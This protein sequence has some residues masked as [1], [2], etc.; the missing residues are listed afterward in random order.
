MDAATHEQEVVEAAPVRLDE[1]AMSVDGQTLYVASGGALHAIPVQSG[2]A[3]TLS[4]GIAVSH[5]FV[6]PQG[7]FLVAASLSEGML[8]TLTPAGQVLDV[9]S[10]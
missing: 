9:I 4:A 5:V 7:D 8:V 2:P 1:R 6:R 10:L 3:T